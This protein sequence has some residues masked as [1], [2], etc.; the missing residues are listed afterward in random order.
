MIFDQN[1][2]NEKSISIKIN[3]LELTQVA[4]PYDRFDTARV[5]II[6]NYRLEQQ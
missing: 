4:S 3:A 1:D 6:L 2:V 5:P